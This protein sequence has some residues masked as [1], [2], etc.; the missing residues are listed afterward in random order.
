MKKVTTI[1]MMVVVV[2]AF[3]LSV[4]YDICSNREKEKRISLLE[5]VIKKLTDSHYAWFDV[6]STT[7]SQLQEQMEQLTDSTD[8]RFREELATLADALMV[9]YRDMGDDYIE[10]V[11]DIGDVNNR[12]D[13]VLEDYS[14]HVSARFETQVKLIEDLSGRVDEVP[15]NLLPKLAKQITPSIVRVAVSLGVNEWTGEDMGWSGSGVFV[16]ENLILTAGHVVDLDS[17]EV[18]ADP[19][20]LYKVGTPVG[21]ELVDGTKLKVVGVYMEDAR[22]TDLGVIEVEWPDEIEARSEPLLFGTAEIGETVFAIGEPFGFF[23]T[24]TSGIVSALDVDIEDDF[25]G[26]AN[27]LQTDCPINPGN[28]GCPLFNMKGKIVGICVGIYCSD[29]GRDGIGFCVPSHVCQKVI[30]KYLASKALEEVDVN[31]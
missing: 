23:P 10:L 5:S 20:Y 22:I 17:I 29:V 25:W 9:Y 1:L 19:E 26:A 6:V 4:R 28:S 12:V 21:V 27:V 18:Y 11:R 24:V 30:D 31:D 13:K 8:I 15:S 7:K 3:S 2:L 16:R 14:K